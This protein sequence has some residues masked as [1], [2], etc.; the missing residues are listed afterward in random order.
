MRPS[1]EVLDIRMPAW[2]KVLG[3]QMSRNVPPPPSVTHRL[4]YCPSQ[5]RFRSGS[6]VWLLLYGFSRVPSIVLVPCPPRKR[7]SF[8]SESLPAIH[9]AATARGLIPL[10]YKPIPI[11]MLVPPRGASISGLGGPTPGNEGVESSRSISVA[12]GCRPINT[13]S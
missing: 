12:L 13:V 9:L 11:M 2:A 1:V 4:G 7:T 6:A 3:V 5:R 8:M 10:V